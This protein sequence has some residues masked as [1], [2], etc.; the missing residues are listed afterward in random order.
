MH[1]RNHIK[2]MGAEGEAAPELRIH[3]QE[4]FGVACRRLLLLL[5]YGGWEIRW[6]FRQFEPGARVI[7]IRTPKAQSELTLFSAVEPRL[8]LSPLQGSHLALI[9][10][11]V[12]S[13]LEI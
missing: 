5:G 8:T 3:K 11:F 12:N 1:K 2:R 7:A 10:K 4:D 6:G 13:D 9:K